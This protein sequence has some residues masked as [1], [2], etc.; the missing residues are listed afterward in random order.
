MNRKKMEITDAKNLDAA[1]NKINY[2]GVISFFKD[3]KPLYN[4]AFGYRDRP[5]QIPNTTT[6]RFGIASGTKLLTALGIL[7]L[8]EKDK[9]RLESTIADI[10]TEV[11][12]YISS[13]ATIKDL[14]THSSGIYDYYDEELIDDFDHF[15]VDIPWSELHTPSDY[16]PL[17]E[18]HQPKF[19]PGE[20]FS[21]SNGGYVFLGVIIERIIGCLYRDYIKESVLQPA[22]MMSSGF[23]AFNELP[24]HTANGY[25]SEETGMKTNIY[26][27]PVRG[28]GDG[29]MYTT[30]ADI[31]KLWHSL[32]KGRLLGNETV[33]LM[34]RKEWEITGTIHYGLG[35]YITEIAGASCYFITGSDA[36]VGFHSY[37]FPG[38]DLLVNLF[39]NTSSG[40]DEIMRYCIDY[41]IPR[42]LG[43]TGRSADELCSRS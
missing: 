30:T 1:A 34:C 3:E 17:F 5:N 12:L 21:Y 8:I 19:S 7:N 2:S 33:K 4:K 39:S 27:L 40:T 38:N 20:R 42:L 35:V 22:G 11:P 25:L 26:Q 24:A 15:S 32:L 23:F 10:F 16:L 36:G 6:T 18:D 31:M 14:L 41:E 37:Y 28:G 29:G 43:T 9:L 13:A